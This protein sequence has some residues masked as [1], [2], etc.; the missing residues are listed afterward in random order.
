M[1]TLTFR[2]TADTAAAIRREAC[3]QRLNLSE[4]LRAAATPEKKN[5]DG[6][7]IPKRHPISGFWYNA[8]PNQ[9]QYTH[10]ELKKF[11]EDFP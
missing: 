5:A 9:P 7:F 2:V 6:Q 4:Y 3:E 11:L 8:A 10:E 1:E